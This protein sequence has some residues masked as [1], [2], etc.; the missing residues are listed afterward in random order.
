MRREKS[1][2]MDFVRVRVPMRGT[3]VEAYG[4]RNGSTNICGARASAH[5]TGWRE[6]KPDNRS[7]SHTGPNMVRLDYK[8][9]MNREIHVRIREGVEVRLLCATRLR[10]ILARRH[11]RIAIRERSRARL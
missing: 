3:G 1:K 7:C 5:G 10:K 2:R 6:S 8:G 9:R 11:M 4:E